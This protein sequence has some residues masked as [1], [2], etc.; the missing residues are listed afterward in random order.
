M[1][2]ASVK[3]KNLGNWSAPSLTSQKVCMKILLALAQEQLKNFRALKHFSS[4]FTINYSMYPFFRVHKI[5]REKVSNCT[6]NIKPCSIPG[7][8]GITPKFVKLASCI[9]S[10]YLAKLFDIMC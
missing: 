4:E 3:T 2:L 8:D 6:S 10:P 5:T 7:V 9:L 1:R